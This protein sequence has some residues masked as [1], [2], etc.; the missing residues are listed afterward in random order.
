MPFRLP[1]RPRIGRAVFQSIRLVLAA[2]IAV[3]SFAWMT[4]IG[5]RGFLPSMSRIVWIEAG[6]DMG[7]WKFRE[8]GTGSADSRPPPVAERCWTLGL[9]ESSMGR[10]SGPPGEWRAH[11]WT[12]FEATDPAGLDVDVTTDPSMTSDDF[13]RLL[14]AFVRREV[15]PT[16]QALA[17][18]PETPAGPVQYSCDGGWQHWTVW[19][20]RGHPVIIVLIA[21]WSLGLGLG[22]ALIL[23]P[24]R[25]Q[26]PTPAAR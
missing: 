8:A 1:N 17:I 2:V 6:Q 26:T 25:D 19:Q 24:P 21:A 14:D 12:V 22:V 7:T 20:N 11:S 16:S 23:E 13:H 15:I 10:S 5:N 3:V 4:N 9:R 18:W